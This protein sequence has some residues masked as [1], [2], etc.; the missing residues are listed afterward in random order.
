MVDAEQANKEADEIKTGSE[1]HKYG[2]DVKVNIKPP[3]LQS[4]IAPVKFLFSYLMDYAMLGLFPIAGLY[5]YYVY[6]SLRTALT[7]HKINHPDVYEFNPLA[8]WV[9]GLLPSLGM[10]MVLVFVAEVLLAASIPEGWMRFLCAFLAAAGGGLVYYGLYIP[11]LYPWKVKWIFI[12]PIFASMD[13]HLGCPLPAGMTNQDIVKFSLYPNVVM[14]GLFPVVGFFLRYVS[15]GLRKVLV[16]HL[17]QKTGMFDRLF[18]K[19]GFEKEGKRVW[20]SSIILTVIEYIVVLVCAPYVN[21]LIG[22]SDFYFGETIDPILFTVLALCI[23]LSIWLTSSH[24]VNGKQQLDDLVPS[25]L[26]NYEIFHQLK[27][28]SATREQVLAA[29]I[30]GWASINPGLIPTAIKKQN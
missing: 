17:F 14:L 16:D 1:K 28:G 8:Q 30:N 23:D 25:A 21:K 26:R 27:P 19:I 2:S 3:G 29:G 7:E 6:H 11:Y 18:Q 22:G 5:L 4:R 15:R 24:D 20:L 10:L 13:M 12:K 9:F